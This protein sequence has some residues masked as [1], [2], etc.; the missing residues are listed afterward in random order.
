M[1]EMSPMLH[2]IRAVYE[3]G[4]LRPLETINLQEGEEVELTFL[5]QRDKARAILSDLLAPRAELPD[6]L[7]GIDEEA[8]I[9]EIREGFKDV[10]SMSDVIIAERREGR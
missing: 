8:L 4:L 3:N 6:E 9:A 10:P 7:E 2:R 5:S 1:K